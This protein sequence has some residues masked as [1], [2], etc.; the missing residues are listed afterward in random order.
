MLIVVPLG[1]RRG[2]RVSSSDEENGEYEIS[3]EG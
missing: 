2:S 3:K 1:W